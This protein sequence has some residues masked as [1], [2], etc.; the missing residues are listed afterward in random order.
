MPGHRVNINLARRVM[1]ASIHKARR[2][3]PGGGALYNN[4]GQIFSVHKEMVDAVGIVIAF[5]NSY[6]ILKQPCAET[7][8]KQPAIQPNTAHGIV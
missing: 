5:R 6:C 7:G 2:R 3:A 8:C 1:D 4:Q